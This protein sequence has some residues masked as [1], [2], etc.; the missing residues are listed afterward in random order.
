MLSQLMVENCCRMLGN[1]VDFGFPG[2]SSDFRANDS[3]FGSDPFCGWSVRPTVA[4]LRAV[5]DETKA[6]A[7]AFVGVGERALKR[8][9][10][11]PQL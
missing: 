1:A 11:H 10:R 6:H 4:V 7:L 3:S 5:E 9:R 2:C 8:K